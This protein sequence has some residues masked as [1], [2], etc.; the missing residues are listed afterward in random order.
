[1]LLCKGFI[2]FRNVILVLII[3]LI[4]SKSSYCQISDQEQQSQISL[5][6]FLD[7]LEERFNVYFI[8]ESGILDNSIFY[9]S[10]DIFTQD[11]ERI[12]LEIEDRTP[13][14]VYSVSD[15]A[16]IMTYAIKREDSK[17]R[18]SGKIMDENNKGLEFATIYVP[19]L[20]LGVAANLGGNYEFELDA[21]NHEIEVS[22]VG[23][24]TTIVKVDIGPG[25]SEELD[26]ILKGSEFIKEVLVTGSR[27]AVV[28]A[29]EGGTT[30]IEHGVIA[31][32][33]NLKGREIDAYVELSELLHIQQPSAHSVHQSVSDGTDHIDAVT[34]RGMGPDQTL[35]L[36]N[37]KRRHQSALL[38]ISNT[39]GKGSVMTDLNSI[40]LS[41]IDRIE[42][43]QDGAAAQ[44]GSDAIAGVINVILK[45]NNYSEINF[46]SGVSKDGDGLIYDFGSN[47]G[48][49]LDERGSFLNLSINHYER[50]PTN[51]TNYYTGPIFKDS[52]KDVNTEFL[53]DFYNSVPFDSTIVTRFGQAEIYSNTIF[54]NLKI[55][56]NDKI[57]LY[58]FGGY[59]YKNGESVGVYRFPYQLSDNVRPNGW[60]FSPLLDTDITDKAFTVG[61]QNKISQH[62]VLD[63][64]NTSGRNSIVYKILNPAQGL[65]QR[66]KADV[67]AGEALYGQNISNIDYSHSLQYDIPI[68]LSAGAEIRV[69]NYEQRSGD[70]ELKT[71]DDTFMDIETENL[72][73]FP[74]F[75]EQ[76]GLSEYRTNVGVYIDAEADL[77]KELKLGASARFERYDD[78][79]ANLSWKVFA[80]YNPS[81]YLSFKVSTNT[82]FRAPSLHQYYYT[83]SLNQFVPADNG[84][85]KAIVV[86]HFNHSSENS[87][88]PNLDI[89]PLKAESSFNVNLGIVARPIKNL[90]V[91]LNAYRIDVDDRI[92]LSGRLSGDFNSDIAAALGSSSDIQF[93][94]NAIGTKTS[95]IEIISKYKILFGVSNTSLNL[96]FSGHLNK[97]RIKE[98]NGSR[99]QNLNALLQPFEQDIYNRSEVALLESAQPNSNFVFTSSLQKGKLGIHAR[100]SRYGS[101]K[102]V[103]PL[104]GDPAQWVPNKLTDDMEPESRDQTFSAKYLTDF[105]VQ[106]SFTT[107]VALTFGGSNIFNIYPDEQSHSANRGDGM[108]PYSRFVTQFGTRGAFGYANLNI[109]F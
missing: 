24:E 83:S 28:N 58:S 91:A 95:G 62:S 71:Y 73:L 27:N 6:S 51:R 48:F 38:N 10:P 54:Y 30:I 23:K 15:N 60:G 92:I 16:D 100:L 22:F 13:F 86:N 97:N 36:I 82:G 101:I 1:M 45:E 108:Y 49:K 50:N 8:N 66:T 81:D 93:F 42:I 3:S 63:V 85:F 109:K 2:S 7:T 26:F 105:S 88:L 17:A 103:H 20:R 31:N 34:L 46:K 70:E 89:D 99:L 12:F 87:V 74:R 106:F 104:D 57:E 44:Y 14:K 72:Q 21:G 69:E 53:D 61:F 77:S 59:S 78:F 102:Y 80:R 65:G 19:S 76:D 37:G 32:L 96:S 11:I 55:P 9:Y 56:I 43:L 68:T 67:V 4:A 33:I 90:S 25:E 98:V 35:V 39:I 5:E 29:L 18:L 40:P 75:G 52:S 41:I 94:T 79:G 107:N 47:F 84:S 64:S